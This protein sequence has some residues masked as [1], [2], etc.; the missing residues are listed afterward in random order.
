MPSKIVILGAGLAGCTLARY[1][2]K[3]KYDITIL[4]K[5]DHVGG[6]CS[7]I[8]ANGYQHD[9]GGHIL[10]SKNKPL[11]E[12]MLSYL[13]GNVK[14]YRRDNR[15]LFKGEYLKYPIENGFG[16]STDKQFVIDCL[17]GYAQ[18]P[19]NGLTFDTWLLGRYGEGF[20]KH[21]LFPYNRKLWKVPLESISTDW[22][23]RLPDPNDE[24]IWNAAF[25]IETE[26][27]KH[28][29]NFWYP[30]EGG[31]QA[32]PE[33][34]LGDHKQIVFNSCVTRISR[35]KNKWLVQ[36]TEQDAGLISSHYAD[37]VISTIPLTQLTR[38]VI[39][40][41]NIRDAASQL[42]HLSVLIYPGPD[43][44][45]FPKE[46]FAIYSGAP[47]FPWHRDCNYRLLGHNCRAFE[48]SFNEE[49][50][51]G[52]TPD[53]YATIADYAYPIHTHT[54]REAV[55]TI[56]EYLLEQDIHICGRFGEWTY[57]NMDEVF[58][59]GRDLA[60]RLNSA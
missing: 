33:A 31:I 39:V 46:A 1:L 23:D 56:G 11:L 27:Y 44:G 28:Q 51:L 47:S 12:E 14:Q 49:H 42:K 18:R 13:G 2:D 25:G 20:C 15:V 3:D 32:L 48:Y 41:E 30:K 19:I 24:D 45:T 21:Y 10:F 59:R 6:L 38:I 54:R 29:L 57:S 58:E 35:D 5:S 55:A 4:E 53:D 36:C 9:L 22:V 26:G 17:S 60:K 8:K 16:E 43:I 50:P 52:Y 40:P 7:T 37:I 34:I